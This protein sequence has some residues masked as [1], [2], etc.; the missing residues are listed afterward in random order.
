[1][2]SIP[3]DIDPGTLIA[4][5][6]TAL[7]HNR[8]IANNNITTHGSDLNWAICALHALLLI[9]VIVW[10]YMTNPR[11]RV[12]HY[13]AI[14]ILSV[15]TVYYF[16]IASNLGGAAVPVE[17]RGGNILN[18]T[19][20]VFY[21]RWVG[22]LINFSIIW[23]A[24]LLMSGVGWAS[25]LFTTGLTMLWSSMFLMGMFVRSSYKWG[26][27]VFAIV[28]WALITWQT[29]GIARSYAGTI[30]ATTHRT[31]SLLAAWTLFFMMLYPISWALS[32]GSNRITNDAEQIFYSVLDVCSQGVFSLV[33][34]FLSRRLDFD[35]LG[36]AFTEYGRIK[37]RIS[38]KMHH[39]N[40]TAARPAGGVVSGHQ[41]AVEGYRND[42]AQ[43][44]AEHARPRDGI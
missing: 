27:F 11:R 33:L 6:N 43:A 16:I 17:F 5:A 4:R 32:E 38:E 19:R 28:L 36:L 3:I 34:L 37:N 40:G 42:V 30:D 18:R 39:A 23:F 26:F 25:I 8:P 24:L 10:T 7:D 2:P 29:M 20:Q 31:F 15:A 12:F 35:I 13:F 21:A 22:Y 14:S 9:G 41:N 44:H 1:M